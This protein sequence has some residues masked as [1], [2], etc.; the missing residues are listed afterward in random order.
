MSRVWNDRTYLL[1]VSEQLEGSRLERQAELELCPLVPSQGFCGRYTAV[2]NP[3]SVAM[4]LW[5]KEA[6]RLPF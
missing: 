2:G 5:P 6:L 3:G 4:Q 1:T